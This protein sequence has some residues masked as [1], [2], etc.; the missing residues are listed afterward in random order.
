MEI[1]ISFSFKILQR[2]KTQQKPTKKPEQVR[3][4]LALPQSL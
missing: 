1:T 2:Q 3:S 4:S